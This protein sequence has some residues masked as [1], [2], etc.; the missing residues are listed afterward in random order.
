MVD[1]AHHTAVDLDPGRLDTD[2]TTCGGLTW[3]CAC[4]WMGIGA[5][6]KPY[7][8]WDE[9]EN[10]LKPICPTQVKRARRAIAKAIRTHCPA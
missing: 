5:D 8:E 2:G 3:L 6:G 7:P 1:S 10:D 4:K 9:P